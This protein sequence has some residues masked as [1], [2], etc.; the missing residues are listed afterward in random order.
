M[1]LGEYHSI[2]LKNLQN[3]FTFLKGDFHEALYEWRNS[4]LA[5]SICF[6]RGHTI[7]WPMRIGETKCFG[8]FGF[9][10]FTIFLFQVY[11]YLFN[12][13]LFPE[14]DKFSRVFFLDWQEDGVG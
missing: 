11:E 14:F 4:S 13:Q 7:C 6:D 1:W 5:Y 9:K 8:D 10:C 3:V 2:R 12:K